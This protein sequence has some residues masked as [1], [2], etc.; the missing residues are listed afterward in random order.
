FSLRA[1]LPHSFLVGS[2]PLSL[3]SR[4][5]G[6]WVRVFFPDG[7]LMTDREML[8]H[9]SDVLISDPR[10]LSLQERELLSNLLQLAHRFNG[11]NNVAETIARAVGETVAGR[12]HEALGSSIL[13]RIAAERTASTSNT[14]QF[15]PRPPSPGPPSPGVGLNLTEAGTQSLPPRPPSPGP[16]SP[17]AGFATATA[18]Y[19]ESVLVAEPAEILP[20]HCVILEEFLPPQ[21]LENLIQDTLRH[22]SEF[23]LSEVVSP[24]VN[25]GGTDF[26]HRR[27]RVLLNIG[28][29]GAALAACVKECLP[30]ILPDLG[31]ETFPVSRVEAQITASNDGDFFRWYKYSAL[32]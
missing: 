13:Q 10:L 31:H 22:E 7:T 20:A 11:D 1:W 18:A 16:P 8:D 32:E 21:E 26:E 27:S 14:A 12:M 28:R 17:G 3:Y 9:F 19:S 6:A 2:S 15:P 24:G 30:G 4:L 25:G 5:S 23:H 29:H